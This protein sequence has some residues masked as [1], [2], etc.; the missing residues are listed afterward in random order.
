MDIGDD[1]VQPDEPSLIIADTPTEQEALTIGHP[2][3]DL[4]VKDRLARLILAE[5]FKAS[6]NEHM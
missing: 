6:V 5:S 2:I 4:P 1:D 3:D